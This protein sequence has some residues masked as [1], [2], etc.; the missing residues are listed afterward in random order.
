MVNSTLPS[1]QERSLCLR[2]DAASFNLVRENIQ[3]LREGGHTDLF[4]LSEEMKNFNHWKLDKIVKR[5]LL[6]ELWNVAYGY[7]P[8]VPVNTH[9]ILIKKE[10]LWCFFSIVYFTYPYS[11]NFHK[12]IMVV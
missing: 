7:I 1:A 11:L 10:K 12:T 2:S 8:F 5:Y 6:H 3:I 9:T 4:Y